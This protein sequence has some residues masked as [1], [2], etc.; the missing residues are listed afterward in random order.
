MEECYAEQEHKRRFTEA[1]Q[2][3]M[4]VHGM[5]QETPEHTEN[6]VF[7]PHEGPLVPY[8]HLLFEDPQKYDTNPD[9]SE[10]PP[11]AGWSMRSKIWT[12]VP[13]YQVCQESLYDF[14]E[15]CAQDQ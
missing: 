4:E 6:P 9:G 11:F 2:D 5:L 3:I 10:L 15:V 13:E 7:N 14:L 12:L 8:Y 1:L